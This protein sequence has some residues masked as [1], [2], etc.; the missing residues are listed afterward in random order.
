VLGWYEVRGGRGG[1]R[2]C[3]SGVLYAI[4]VVDVHFIRPEVRSQYALTNCSF[5]E[6]L[7]SGHYE[8]KQVAPQAA[9]TH[10]F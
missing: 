2:L 3:G 4:I 8:A 6:S 9:M 5:V 1:G 10:H 7:L